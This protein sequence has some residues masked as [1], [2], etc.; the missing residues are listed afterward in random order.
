MLGYTPSRSYRNPKNFLND[1]NSQIEYLGSY[2]AYYVLASGHGT[3]YQSSVFSVHSQTISEPTKERS[4]NRLLA[5][6]ANDG[7]EPC[8]Q[9]VETYTIRMYVL[10]RRRHICFLRLTFWKYPAI[11]TNYSISHCITLQSYMTRYLGRNEIF[12]TKNNEFNSAAIFPVWHELPRLCCGKINVAGIR[13]DDRK[14]E[15]SAV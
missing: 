6:I 15:N 14:L 8:Q 5:I 9:D 11:H 10:A 4:V 12:N 13:I 3:V 1:L 7:T 2:Y